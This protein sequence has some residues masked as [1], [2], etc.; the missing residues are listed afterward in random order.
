[1]CNFSESGSEDE[2]MILSETVKLTNEKDSLVRRQDYLNLVAALS[3][4]EEKLVIKQQ[5]IN[6]VTKNNGKFVV[7]NELQ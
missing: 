3:E 5:E 2:Q 1:M 6:E 7:E 4:I